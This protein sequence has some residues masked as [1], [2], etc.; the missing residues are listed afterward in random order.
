MSAEEARRRNI[1]NILSSKSLLEAIEKLTINKES[2]VPPTPKTLAEINKK[3]KADSEVTFNV[4]STNT[5]LYHMP[6]SLMI[7][8]NGNYR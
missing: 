3:A 6:S 7:T 4:E 5:V 1:H 2:I 8:Q